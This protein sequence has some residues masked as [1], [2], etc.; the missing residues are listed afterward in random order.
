MQDNNQSSDLNN[1]NSEAK[2]TSNLVSDNKSSEATNS[3]NKIDASKIYPD[4]KLNPLDNANENATQAGQSQALAKAQVE[5]QTADSNRAVSM[6]VKS[7]LVLG[8]F[9]FINA[10]ITIT[11]SSWL[12]Y[13]GFDSFI[14]NIGKIENI[15]FIASIGL[16]VVQLVLAVYLII[17]KDNYRVAFILK[18][19][20][21]L[22]LLSV[23]SNLF[24]LTAL[25]VSSLFLI[26]IWYVYSR[27]KNL[28]YL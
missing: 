22:Q 11:L 6:R 14:T 19:F 21:V 3:N 18:I 24:N 28:N 5:S 4:A 10:A 20:L 8:I 27:V 2:T 26:F 1:E 15:L 23:L 9:Y 25:V 7:L 13:L 12:V 16:V 17:S